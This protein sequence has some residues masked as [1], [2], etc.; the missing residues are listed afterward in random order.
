MLMTALKRSIALFSSALEV[1]TASRALGSVNDGMEDLET[2][3]D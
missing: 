3:L 2:L 1:A